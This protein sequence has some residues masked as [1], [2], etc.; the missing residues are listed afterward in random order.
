[1]ERYCGQIIGDNSKFSLVLVLR[2]KAF[3]ILSDIS[4][5]EQKNNDTLTTLEIRSGNR[6]FKQVQ[7]NQLK[8]RLQGHS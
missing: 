3:D 7:R 8:T 2:D 5:N 4:D 6:Y 1:M